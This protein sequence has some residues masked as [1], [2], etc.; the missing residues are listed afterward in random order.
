[1]TVLASSSSS[2]F[3]TL[4]HWLRASPRLHI[5]RRQT[6]TTLLLQKGSAAFAVI[7]RNEVK[8][9][10]DHVTVKDVRAG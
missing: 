8:R 6:E 1:M 7:V 2:S 10:T 3:S 4:S 5:G 9:A